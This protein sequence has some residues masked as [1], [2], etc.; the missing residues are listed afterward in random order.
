MTVI[1]WVGCGVLSQFF[2]EKGLGSFVHAGYCHNSLQGYCHN[3]LQKKDWG[4][5]FIDIFKGSVCFYGSQY[6]IEKGSVFL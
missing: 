3:S 1:G 2:T 4:Q 6:S 5:Y